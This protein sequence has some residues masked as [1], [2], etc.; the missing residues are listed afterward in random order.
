MPDYEGLNVE[1]WIWPIDKK[2]IACIK[3]LDTPRKIGEYMLENFI[4]EKPDTFS[5]PDS[6][7]TWKTK[8]GNCTS[9]S[10]FG[11]F[12]ADYHGYKVYQIGI[13]FKGT[14]MKHLLTAYV[15][16]NGLSFTSNQEYYN[17]FGKGFNSLNQIVAFN[18]H[19]SDSEYQKEYI[20]RCYQD[21]EISGKINKIKKEG[22][23]N[24]RL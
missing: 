2:F 16:D 19:F 11:A 8:K 1:G 6:Y 23:L 13:S 7:V 10:E 9:F 3:E 24:G 15:E 4:Y 22:E 14:S 18:E 5:F 17:N 12:V 21:R 20:I